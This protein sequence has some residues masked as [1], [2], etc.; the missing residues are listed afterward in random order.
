MNVFLSLKIALTPSGHTRRNSY[1]DMQGNLSMTQLENSAS[2]GGD[3]VH[4]PS[5]RKDDLEP[6]SSG[7]RRM[8][9]LFL[10]R[11]A[12]RIEDFIRAKDAKLGVVPE[13]NATKPDSRSGS[14][15]STPTGTNFENPAS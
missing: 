13:Y 7:M 12:F 15:R 6:D 5:V 1:F 4:L 8:G 3:S 9:A 2:M 11:Q 10:G 14:Y